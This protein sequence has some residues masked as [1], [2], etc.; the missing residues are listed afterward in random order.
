MLKLFSDQIT[1]GHLKKTKVNNNKFINFYKI[2]K[3]VLISLDF[4]V[5][6]INLVL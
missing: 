6:A 3:V 1:T 4:H 5:H 2:I